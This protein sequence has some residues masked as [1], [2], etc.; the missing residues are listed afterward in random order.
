MWNFLW[1]YLKVFN[2]KCYQKFWFPTPKIWMLDPSTI[3]DPV[4]IGKQSNKTKF[5]WILKLMSK[6]S[7]IYGSSILWKS[8]C[9]QSFVNAKIFT[10]CQ[11]MPKCTPIY[12][13]FN[14]YSNQ[15]LFVLLLLPFVKANSFLNRNAELIWKWK[16]II[17]TFL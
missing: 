1:E 3:P 2:K 13:F 8:K 11:L 15:S 16:K 5:W 10:N 6:L 4:S 14:F 7:L 12:R 17:R 9:L